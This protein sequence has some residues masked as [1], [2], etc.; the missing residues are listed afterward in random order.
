MKKALITGVSGQDGAFLAK[1]LLEKGY[2]VYGFVRSR[3]SCWRLQEL[4]LLEKI[5]LLD[6]DFENTKELY[7]NLDLIQPDEIYNLVAQSSVAKSFENP[8]ETIWIDGFWVSHILEW[9]R[10]NKR[11]TRFFQ[12]GSGEIFGISKT[13]PQTEETHLSPNNPYSTA[14]VFAHNLVKNYRELYGIFAVNGILFNHDSELRGIN[15]FT[16]K[17]S[18]HIAGYFL[19]KKSI[20]EVGNINVERDIGYAKEYVEAMYLSLQVDNP[21]DYVIA[22]GTSQS[23]KNFITECFKVIHIDLIWQTNLTYQSGLDVSTGEVLVKVNPSYFRHFEIP[24]QLGDPTKAKQI[25]GWK[26]KTTLSELAKIMVEYDI[27]FLSNQNIF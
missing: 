4:K 20:L 24:K 22:T 23:I 7:E 13:F 14:K 27:K 11:E 15:F 21:S 6:L 9:I 12:A 16:R 8:L 17:V 26:A 19:G 25:L 5:N 10:K 3:L 1:L 2:T 18:N